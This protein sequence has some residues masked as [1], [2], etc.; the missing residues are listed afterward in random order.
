[1][2]HKCNMKGGRLTAANAACT[3]MPKPCQRMIREQPNFSADG[4][5]CW[6]D[7]SN[8][9]KK[10]RLDVIHDEGSCPSCT[11]NWHS[12]KLFVQHGVSWLFLF[13]DPNN[14]S[15]FAPLLVLQCSMN[16]HCG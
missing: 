16:E 12:K 7:S 8:F 9:K 13:I 5:P 2:T 3:M 10:L 1:M 11:I 6:P 4:A 14:A 15:S